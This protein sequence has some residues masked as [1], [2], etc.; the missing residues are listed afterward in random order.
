[1]PLTVIPPPAFPKPPAKALAVPTTFLSNQ[2]VHQTWQGTNEA[3]RIPTKNLKAMRPCGVLTRPA[4]AVGM[5]PAR[6][7]PTKTYRGPKRS[8]NGP[9]RN[10]MTSVPVRAVMLEFEK[11]ACDIFKSERM[12][13]LRSGGKAY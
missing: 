6:R 9:A 12:V 3:P 8:H 13:L 10:R 4:I 7:H 5:D 2:P 1:M 11:S